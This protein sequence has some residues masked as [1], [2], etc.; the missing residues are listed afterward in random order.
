[1]T[2]HVDTTVKFFHSKM[3][4]A[5]V[6]R[7]QAGSLIAI[8]DACLVNG[9]GIQTASSVI[10]S[11]GVCTMTFPLDHAAPVDAVVLVAG[12]S[13]ADLNGEQKV[14]YAGPNVLKF[15]TAAANGTATGAITAKMAPAGWEKR[16]TGTNLAVYR[17]LDVSSTKFHLR[18]NDAN[19]IATRV[20][21]YET[22]TAVSSGTGLFPTNAQQSGGLYW[23]KSYAAGTDEI[24]WVIISN[25]KRLLFGVAFAASTGYGGPTYSAMVLHGF[26][27]FTSWKSIVDSYNCMILGSP[28]VHDM[29]ANFGLPWL[30]GSQGLYI[31][32]SVAGAAGAVIAEQIP[33]F[34]GGAQEGSGSSALW[35]EFPGT[36]G[37]L[38][39]AQPILSS[40]PPALTGPRG[41]MSELFHCPQGILQSSR[42]EAFDTVSGSGAATGR[43]LLAVAC[44]NGPNDPLAPIYYPA[45]FIDIT[46]PWA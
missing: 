34:S 8:L 32:R 15:A 7:G 11:G 10:V 6:L 1:M 35:G 30:Y 45:T 37:S 14:T 42:I 17:S 4:G 26:G 25:G 9:W 29:Y 40:S 13:M 41:V 44:L 5:P 27:D 3:L 24:P 36:T 23:T 2:S 46:G 12:A 20:A 38:I 22:M 16:F 31:A 19:A 18:V 39:L 43:K 28:A 33:G 21:G